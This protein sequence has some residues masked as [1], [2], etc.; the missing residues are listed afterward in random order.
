MVSVD[1]D[2][3]FSVFVYINVIK[4]AV[5]KPMIV[6]YTLSGYFFSSF[7]IIFV[8]ANMPT[9]TPKTRGTRLNQ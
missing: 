1:M 5:T 9:T 6:I 3:V 4:E 8:V 2:A 7:S